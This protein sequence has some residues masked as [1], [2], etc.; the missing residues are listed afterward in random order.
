[1]FHPVG[2]WQVIMKAITI[3]EFGQSDRM[4]LVEIEKPQPAVGEILLRVKAAGVN[5]VDWKIREGLLRDRL[6]HEFPIILGWDAA[7]IVESTGGG[8]T[9]W[10]IGDEV[11]AYCRKPVV[12]W[13]TYAE[14]VAVPETFCARMPRNMTFEEAATVPL[15][16]LTAWQSLF[17][18]GSLKSG[19]TV[20]IHAGA[21]GVGGFAVQ[22]AKYT[23]AH[24]ISTG[25][26]RNHEFIRRLGADEVIDYSLVDFRE[27]VRTKFPQGIDLAFDTVG[28]DIFLRSADVLKDGGRLVSIVH[29]D[30]F[31]K[32]PPRVVFEYVFVRP[33]QS[34]LR[35][36]TKLI[37]SGALRTHVSASFALT[38]DEAAEA[39]RRSKAGHTRGK[40]AIKIP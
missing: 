18:A 6:P 13:G 32:V 1:M 2:K 7:G 37:E 16:A 25:L 26:L 36:L 30:A 15:A 5:P 12:K 21:G 22:L 11:Y 17:E 33:E 39:L 38:A 3:E 28:G 19:Q 4:K 29:N 23:G 10:S 9:Q 34:Q 27:I 20:L 35:E 31:D 40:M 24:V 14:Y 8:V